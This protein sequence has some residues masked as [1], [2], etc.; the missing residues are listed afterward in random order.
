MWRAL[1]AA[2]LIPAGAQAAAVTDCDE[3]ASAWNLVE[4]WETHSASYAKGEIRVAVI[5]TGDPAAAAVHLLVFSPPVGEAGFRQCRLVSLTAEGSGFHDLDFPAR[6][7]SY[8]PA[9]GLTLTI[10]AETFVPE[11]GQGTPATLT[12]TIDQRSG[13]VGAL[14]Q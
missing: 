2:M 13:K 12:V 7:A 8:D 6:K 14:L 1:C 4:P 5:D 3:K 10:P 11:T 9:R